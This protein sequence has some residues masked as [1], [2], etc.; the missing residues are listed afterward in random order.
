MQQF[1]CILASYKN[2]PTIVKAAD[3][4]KQSDVDQYI[5]AVLNEHLPL[6]SVNALMISENDEYIDGFA[7]HVKDKQYSIL[8]KE[9]VTNSGWFSTWTTEKVN[10]IATFSILDYN[11]EIAPENVEAKEEDLLISSIVSNKALLLE[12][13]EELK[14]NK[15]FLSRQN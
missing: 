2:I 15:L 4:I 8:Q 11:Y 14:K 7:I 5:R 13:Q 12:L 6:P 9:E 1:Q 10:L 3:S